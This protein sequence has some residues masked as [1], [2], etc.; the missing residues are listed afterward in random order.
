MLSE[1]NLLIQ[2]LLLFNN[3]GG[4]GY[5]LLTL[6]NTILEINLLTYE[7]YLLRTPNQPYYHSAVEIIIGLDNR[8]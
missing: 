8:Q 7:Y 5:N 6:L 4:G 3:F 1:N 2:M